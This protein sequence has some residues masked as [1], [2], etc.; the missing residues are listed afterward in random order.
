MF[1]ICFIV[2]VI[3][4]AGGP[5]GTLTTMD[6]MFNNWRVICHRTYTRDLYKKI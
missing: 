5:E 4:V 6:K 2:I 3:V 1:I